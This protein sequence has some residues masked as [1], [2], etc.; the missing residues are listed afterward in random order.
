MVRPARFGF[1]LQTASSNSFQNSDNSS[2]VHELAMHEFDGLKLLLEQSGVHVVV[3]E[4]PDVHV[5]DAIFPNNW[6][7]THADGTLVLYPMMAPNRRLERRED[8]VE[9]IRQYSK[10][11][12]FIDIRERENAGQFLEGTGSIVFDHPA[13]IAY[14]VE[15]PRTDA[16]LLL[17]LCNQLGYQSFVFHAYDAQGDPVYHTNVVMCMTSSAAVVCMEAVAEGDRNQLLKCLAD[18]GRRLIDISVQQMNSFAGNMLSLENHQGKPLLVLSSSA[19]SA[20]TPEQKEIL[21]ADGMG[22][23]ADIPVIERVGGG[24]VRCMLAELFVNNK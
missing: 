5:P 1:N 15:S 12:K 23:V 6:F 3:L 16:Q 4:H 19:L 22:V 11:D 7:S 8:F 18:S 21:F 10:S 14:A 13:R 9:V 17:E 2:Q 20:F 24:G